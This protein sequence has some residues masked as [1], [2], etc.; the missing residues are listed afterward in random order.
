IAKE[1]AKRIAKALHELDCE[2]LRGSRYTGEYEDLFFQVE[3]QLLS[4]AGDIAGN[5]HLA[6]SR[7]DMG[8][9]IYRMVLREKLLLA[10]ASA[11]HL[12]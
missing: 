6:R 11:L 8:V 12:K 9:T 2:A 1:D 7:N 10:I 5:L 3:S 4:K